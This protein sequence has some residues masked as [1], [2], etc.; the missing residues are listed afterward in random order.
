MP[1]N[2][3]PWWLKYVNKVMIGL[4]R[5]GVLGENGPVILE[6]RGRKTGKPRKTP[7]TPMVVDGHRYVV[8]GIPGSDW[9]ANVRAAGEATLHVGRRAE[10]VRMV[11]MPT[12]DA[13]PLLRAFP[14]KVPTGVDFMKNAGLV[15]GPHPDEFEALAGRCPV[16]RIDT[17][18]A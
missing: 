5:L 13:R 14:E 7:V 6:V 8:G 3:L 1:S 15:T 18:S 16:F 2:S 12:E 4:Q 9:A 10:R 11:E 17:V